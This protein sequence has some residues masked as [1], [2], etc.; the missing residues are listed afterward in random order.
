MLSV[1]HLI[2]AKTPQIVEITMN[3]FKHKGNV[4]LVY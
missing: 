1:I 2:P 4:K 3:G